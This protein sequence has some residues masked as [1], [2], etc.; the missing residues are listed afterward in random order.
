MPL[1]CPESAQLAQFVGRSPGTAADALVGSLGFDK[2]YFVTEERVQ[3][4]PRRPG[5]L[6]HDCIRIPSFRK[7]KWH[8]TLSL[9]RRHSCRRLLARA[10][11]GRDESRPGRQECLRHKRFRVESMIWKTVFKAERGTSGTRVRGCVA[12][13]HDTRRKRSLDLSSGYDMQSTPSSPPH[14]NYPHASRHHS[15]QIPSR[16]WTHIAG[17]LSP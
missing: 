6:P 11:A 7:T 13:F 10:S 3:G 5:G 8:W 12:I 14:L 2:A 9:P 1:S 17:C 16:R 15:F 4:D